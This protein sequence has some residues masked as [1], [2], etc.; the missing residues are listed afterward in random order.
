MRDEDCPFHDLDSA[1]TVWY[2]ALHIAL[3]IS[4]ERGCVMYHEAVIIERIISESL[5]ADTG[6]RYSEFQT[7]HGRKRV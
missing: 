1:E 2:K 5:C 6:S 7:T 4:A 3:P